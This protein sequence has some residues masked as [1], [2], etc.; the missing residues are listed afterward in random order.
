MT[1]D[2]KAI[3]L[4]LFIYKYNKFICKI[5]KFAFIFSFFFSSVFTHLFNK[6]LC[7]I[8]C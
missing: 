7:S 3:N 8:V 5:N 1:C 4:H 6:H 2:K